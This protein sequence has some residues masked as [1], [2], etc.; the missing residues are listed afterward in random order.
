MLTQHCSNLIGRGKGMTP[1][2]PYISFLVSVSF[3]TQLLKETRMQEIWMLFLNNL[4]S[5][6]PEA[7]L[8]LPSRFV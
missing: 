4:I 1:I 6:L 7:N 3:S 5:Q 2:F 8:Y